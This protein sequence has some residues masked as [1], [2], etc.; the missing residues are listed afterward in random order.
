MPPAC[1]RPRRRRCGSHTRARSRPGSPARRDPDRTAAGRRTYTQHDETAARRFGSD[2]RE[3]CRCSADSARRG[4]GARFS[5][6]PRLT[7]G[8]A[9]QPPAIRDRAAAGAMSAT[10][11][12][13]AAHGAGTKLRVDAVMTEELSNHRPGRWGQLRIAEK[14]AAARSQSEA[15]W[16]A[17]QA[18]RR[19][20]S[21][22]PEQLSFLSGVVLDDIARPC[23]PT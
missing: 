4:D 2:F 9:P 10:R 18:P 14:G 7:T 5:S 1:A 19:D 8:G 20:A 15:Q 3:W 11:D 13:P 16:R 21:H 12:T 6:R 22:G 23:A 17:R